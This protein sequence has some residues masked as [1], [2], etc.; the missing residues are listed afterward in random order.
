MVKG[1]AI[2]SS[3]FTPPTAITTDVTNTKLL[4][5]FTNAAAFD[6]TGKT[7]SETLGNAQTST[8]TTAKFGTASL[9]LDGTSDSLKLINVVPI[10]TSPFTLEFFFKSSTTSLDTY[11]RRM[12]KWLRLLHKTTHGVK[13]V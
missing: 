10:R 11:Y 7:N 2:Y 13:F 5:N 9:Y 8:A 6:Q 1:T 12:Y 4:A 3:S